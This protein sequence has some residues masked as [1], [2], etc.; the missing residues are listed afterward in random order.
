MRWSVVCN[1]HPNYYLLQGGESK[2]VDAIVRGRFISEDT[3][4]KPKWRS[5]GRIRE[6][7]IYSVLWMGWYCIVF[8]W[9]YTVASIV[10]GLLTTKPI[11]PPPF[12]RTICIFKVQNPS[13]LDCYLPSS[14]FIAICFLIYIYIYIFL[15]ICNIMLYIYHIKFLGRFNLQY[16][17]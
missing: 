9:E 13:C 5:Q 1:K 14:I 12:S 4:K 10:H 17:S 15:Y 2:T 3:R 7:P 6:Y 8:Y 16:L 11:T